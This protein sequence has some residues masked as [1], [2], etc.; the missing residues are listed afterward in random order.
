MFAEQAEVA[1]TVALALAGW[2]AVSVGL[3]GIVGRSIR[4]RDRRAPADLPR[5]R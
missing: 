3:A 4:L 1:T 5:R 2:L